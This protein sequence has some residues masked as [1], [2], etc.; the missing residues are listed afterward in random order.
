MIGLVQDDSTCWPRCSCSRC[1]C[2]ARC[3]KSFVAQ[4]PSRTLPPYSCTSNRPHIERPDHQPIRVSPLGLALDDKGFT[5]D[6][7]LI[8]GPRVGDLGYPQL[9]YRRLGADASRRTYLKV[10]VYL[11]LRLAEPSRL[12]GIA[13]SVRARSWS[14][15]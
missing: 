12:H 13:G 9:E 14:R 1:R 6:G 3:C 2:A 4:E 5:F 11:L 7:E 8:A 10:Q 15:F